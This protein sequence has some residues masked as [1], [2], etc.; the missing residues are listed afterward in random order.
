[1][2]ESRG[3]GSDC[4]DPLVSV[5]CP[6]FNHEE[7]VLE[8]LESLTAQSWQNMEVVM[9][10]DGSTDSTADIAE[11]FT[12]RRPDIFRFRRGKV[13]RG[14]VARW[15]EMVDLIR[16]D[17]LIALGSDDLLPVDGL[18]SR[19]QFMIDHPNVDFLLTEFDLLTADNRLIGGKQKLDVVPQFEKMYRPGIYDRLY[20]ELLRGNFLHP[21]AACYRVGSLE[22]SVLKLD[23]ASPN[24]HD[25]DQLLKIVKGYQVAFLDDAT[26]V[27]RW[28]Q[29]NVSAEENPEKDLVSI[30]AEMS[31][32]LSRQLIGPQTPSQKAITLR[33]I[34]EA[35]AGQKMVCADAVTAA[36]KEHMGRSEWEDAEKLLRSLLAFDP[37]NTDAL[38]TLNVVTAGVGNIP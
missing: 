2:R 27:Y 38:N 30:S 11:E 18:R 31:Y 25:F 7:Y 20:D 19:A 10:D 28:H 9:I 3:V 14:T 5:F 33:T 4:R 21:G 26:Y 29:K 8:M 24:L 6:S 17:F 35:L 12:A 36:A 22:R 34:E 23:P 32:I 13:N 1:M 15:N 37:H 16:G